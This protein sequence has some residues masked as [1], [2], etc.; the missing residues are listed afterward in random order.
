MSAFIAWMKNAGQTKTRSDWAIRVMHEFSC[1]IETKFARAA[2]LPLAAC[3]IG[4]IG[5]IRFAGTR[6]VL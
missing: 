5:T 3:T 2:K 4:T 6:I 1:F